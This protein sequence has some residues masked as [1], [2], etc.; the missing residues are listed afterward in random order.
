[1]IMSK[2]SRREYT[3]RVR[4]RYTAMQTKRARGRVLDDFCA[5]SGL[6]RKHAIKVLRGSGEPL[7]RAGRKSVYAAAREV[8]KAVWLMFDQPCSKLLHPV[9]D[10]RVAAHERHVGALD[11]G[12]KCLLLAMSASTIDRLLIGQ[13]VRTSLWRGRGSPM[14][15]MKRQVPVRE[16]RWEGRA[17]GWFEAD[18][19]AHCGGSMEGSFAYTLTV[20]DTCSQWTEMRAVWNRSGFAVSQRLAQIEAALPFALLGI[21]TDNGPEFLNGHVVRHFRERAT[22]QT[23]S[24]PFHKND[25]PRVEQKNGSLV[26]TLMGYDRFDDPECVEF[27]DEIMRLHSL[28][29]NL[30]RPCMRLLSKERVGHRYRKKYDRPATPAQRVLADPSVVATSQMA[31]RALLTEYDCY[32]LKVGIDKRLEAFFARFVA[33]RQFSPSFPDSGASPSALRAAPSG[34]GLTPELGNQRSAVAAT[35]PSR[36]PPGATTPNVKRSHHR[37]RRPRMQTTA[38][39]GVSGRKATV[40]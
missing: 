12:V 2:E 38:A 15:A 33:S 28:W 25:N 3:L 21:N 24:R 16:Q 27:F 31:I 14:A 8:L 1:M 6:T 7:R 10:S 30:F 29:C 23:R 17:P 35:L 26:R 20:T 36:R 4:E 13:R 34:P 9:M 39:Y 19:V 40:C 18:T 22:P 11:G 32:E 37:A 5:T